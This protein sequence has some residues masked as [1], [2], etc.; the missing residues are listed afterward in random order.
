M[1]FAW[2]NLLRREGAADGERRTVNGERVCHACG[3]PLT[4]SRQP[5]AVRRPPSAVHRQPSAAPS[6]SFY[7][8]KKT[9][10]CCSLFFA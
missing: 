4:V 7:F 6:Y 5:S 1:L 3:N 8:F 10:K 9:N 2:N